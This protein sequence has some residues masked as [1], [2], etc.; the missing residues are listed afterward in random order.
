VNIRVPRQREAEAIAELLTAA[1]EESGFGAAEPAE[2]ESWFTSPTFD[3]AGNFRVA[4]RDGVLLAYCDL[5]PATGE[6]TYVAMDLRARPG[7]AQ[8]A[9]AL[10]DWAGERAAE[11]A[12][13][14]TVIRTGLF[15]RDVS[16]RR[17]LEERG[18]TVVRHSFEM[19]I[20]FDTEPDP[21]SWPPGTELDHLEIGRNERAAFAAFEES[22]RDAWGFVP[23][24]FEE[25]QH[26]RL[27]AHDFEPDLNFLAYDGSEIAG[28]AFCVA[29]GSRHPDYGWIDTLG[30]RRPWRKRGV[31]EA[32]L[33]HAFC[34]FHRRDRRGAGL[35][36]DAESLTGATR[37]YE[38]VGMRVVSRGDT[39]ELEVRPG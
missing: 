26:I 33:R 35:D 13:G 29:A 5:T 17:L 10:A 25:W 32:L 24:P 28:F 38:R 12:A 21:P 36:V 22:F 11:L 8:A 4:E 14:R 3:V 7:E 27:R 19:L 39:Y 37:L 2:V 31:G 30:V 34:E 20:D 6:D 15:E 9:G 1:A 16:K 18:Y 23:R